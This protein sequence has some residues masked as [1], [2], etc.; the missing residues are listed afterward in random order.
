MVNLDGKD[1]GWFPTCAD[2]AEYLS[3]AEKK[4]GISRDEARDKYGGYTYRQW[5]ALLDGG[6]R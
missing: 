1:L 4:F 6:V 2:Y 5:E 3:L